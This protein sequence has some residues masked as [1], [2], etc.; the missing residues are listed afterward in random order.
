M[1]VSSS[2]SSFFNNPTPNTTSASTS[3][4]I[5]IILV[6]DHQMTRLGLRLILEQSTDCQVIAEAEDG[7]TA[8]N[9]V[10]KYP[11]CQ[12]VLMDIGLPEKDGIEATQAI[13]AKRPDLKIMMLTSKD[14]ENNV[15]AALGAGADAYCLKG[16][17]PETLL[18]A[19]RSVAEGDV[20]FDRGIA[21]VVL[22]Y[23][24]GKTAI[25]AGTVA[26][27]AT[28]AVVGLSVY[29]GGDAHL[30][31]TIDCPLTAREMEVLRLIVDGHSN[32]QIADV[33]VITKATAKAHVHSILQK[34]CVDDR[35]QAA[36]LAMRQGLVKG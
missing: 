26:N 29:G 12:L 20:W 32:A 18:A 10:D 25:P 35:T 34:L 9:L 31:T 24:Q 36:V 22:Q 17:S 11:N 15:F 28:G 13:K 3:T 2:S 23:F 30:P 33:L 6:E 7:E 16:A 27:K 8:I 1:S 5:P 21:K 19:I 4:K 14:E